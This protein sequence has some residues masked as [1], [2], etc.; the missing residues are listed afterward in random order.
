[1]RIKELIKYLEVWAPP[2]AAWDRDNTGLQVGFREEKLINLLLCLEVNQDAIRE[3]IN[4]K[5]NLIVTH[6][7]L[8]F[9]PIK[10]LDFQN[11]TNSKL[12]ES[13]TRNKI[14]L[15]SMHTNLD[16]IK[17]GV[18]FE[19]AKELKLKNVHFLKPQSGNQFKLVV[20]APESDI[21]KISDAVFNSGAGR[22][23]EYDKCSYRSKGEGTFLG[24]SN[25]NPALGK[26][27]NFEKVKEERLEF[28]VDSWNLNA[29]IRALIN[30]HSYEEPAYDIYPLKNHSVNYGA[31]AV[32]EL[33]NEMSVKQFLDYVANEMKIKNFRYALGRN[34]KIKTVAVCGGSGSD[35]IDDAVCK[36][37][38]AYITAD[39]KYHAFQDSKLLLID[40]GHYETEIFALNLLKR[41][42]GSFINTKESKVFK[43]TGVTN[44][45][46]FYKQ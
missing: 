46:K 40:A 15:Y 41:R 36:G 7:P 14:T 23:G 1:M 3:A 18:S 6:H 44:P 29:S 43:Y 20:F 8:I 21:E 4:K 10:K 27:G 9:S 37:A 38:D 42:I 11:D 32:G 28:I 13:L 16:Y 19:L 2:G 39:I 35:M 24:S 5:C 22:I 25:T 34:K 12:I 30:A 31:G 17:D 26:K 33:E 45:V